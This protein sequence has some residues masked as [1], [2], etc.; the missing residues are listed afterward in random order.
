MGS[1][2]RKGRSQR[3]HQPIAYIWEQYFGY[4]LLCSR[5]TRKL[6]CSAATRLRS[7]QS[8][9]VVYHAP[10]TSAIGRRAWCCRSGCRS[11]ILQTTLASS[12]PISRR[13]FFPS[14]THRLTFPAGAV[15]GAGARVGAAAGA[16]T[17]MTWLPCSLRLTAQLPAAT[18]G[19][20]GS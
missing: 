18:T 7:C 17:L 11:Q 6:Q 14:C 4:W 12:S 2:R 5:Y 15:F 16:P 20:S 3:H 19:T 8:A 1:K 13:Q 10:T 9:C